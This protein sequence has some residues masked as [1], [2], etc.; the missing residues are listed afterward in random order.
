MRSHDEL[1]RRLCGA[2]P[3]IAHVE[4]LE[5]SG[6]YR[7]AIRLD[8]RFVS[9]RASQQ[10]IENP[11]IQATAADPRVRRLIEGVIAE[12]NSFV[13]ASSRVLDYEIATETSSPDDGSALAA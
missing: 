13:P 4:L 1:E 12:A 7:A 9:S 3:L 10:G 11:S 6:G 8:P 5:A 2:H